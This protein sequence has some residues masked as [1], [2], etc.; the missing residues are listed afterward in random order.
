[1]RGG[2][3]PAAAPSYSLLQAAAMSMKLEFKVVGGDRPLS[4]IE[5]VGEGG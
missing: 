2:G 5:E 4:A 1:V 3:G